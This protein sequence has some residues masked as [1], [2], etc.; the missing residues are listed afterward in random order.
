MFYALTPAWPHAEAFV[1]P[2]HVNIITEQTHEYFCGNEP[3]GRMYGF[4]GRFEARRT[5]WVNLFD[6]YNAVPGAAGNRPQHTGLKRFSRDLRAAS[7][8]LRGKDDPGRRKV[9]LL[10]EL[11]AVK[12]RAR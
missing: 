8:K 9:H 12:G 7:R 11:E 10:W 4:N 3:L 2:T 6:A 5:G 1:D